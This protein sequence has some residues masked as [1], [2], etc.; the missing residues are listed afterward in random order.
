MNTSHVARTD[1]SVIRSS[2]GT[3]YTT[4]D[5]TQASKILSILGLLEA[6]GV[7]ESTGSWLSYKTRMSEICLTSQAKDLASLVGHMARLA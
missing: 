5:W 7:N 1:V 4:E 6:M 3:G 2:G